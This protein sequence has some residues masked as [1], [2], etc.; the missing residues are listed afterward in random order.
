MKH[1]TG[2]FASEEGGN[3][4]V[5]AADEN[6]AYTVADMH[7]DDQQANAALFALAPVLLAALDDLVSACELPRDHCE[8]DQAL[9][10]AIKALDMAKGITPNAQHERTPD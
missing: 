10:S 9:P 6:G 1:T 3:W 5:M 4:R 8:I 7:C 2:L